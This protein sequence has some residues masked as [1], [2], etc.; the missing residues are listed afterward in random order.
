[1]TLLAARTDA[2][3]V[4]QTNELARRF[5]ELMGHKAHPE[6][7]FWSATRGREKQCWQM[8][9]AAQQLLTATDPNDACANMGWETTS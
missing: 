8:A 2:D 4:Q 5:H 9:C 7:C 3:V 1:M 6:F